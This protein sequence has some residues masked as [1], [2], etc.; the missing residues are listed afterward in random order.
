MRI[1]HYSKGKFYLIECPAG[2]RVVRGDSH[3]ESGS[4]GADDLLIVPFQGR[5]LSIPADPPELL[6][7]L[8]E[9]GRCGLALVREPMPNESLAG[10]ECPR[11]D[12][13][14]VRWFSVDEGSSIAH[15]ANCGSDFEL[16][17]QR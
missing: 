7:L 4:E 1:R 2:A 12:G 3:S 11:C 8:A 16:D 14:D 9:S 5:E 6:P 17:G 15:C 10:A 13:E